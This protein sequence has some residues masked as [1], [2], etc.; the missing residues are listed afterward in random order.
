[1]E[2]EKLLIDGYGDRYPKMRAIYNDPKVYSAIKGMDV[3]TIDHMIIIIFILFGN[4]IYFLMKRQEKKL[5]Q[6]GM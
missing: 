6:T 5:A 2:Y 3:Q 4:I 1:S